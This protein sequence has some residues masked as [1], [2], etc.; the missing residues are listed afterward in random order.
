MILDAL[1]V[2][3][4]NFSQIDDVVSLIVSSA[5]G[6]NQAFGGMM[7]VAMMNG[8]IR[9]MVVAMAAPRT[10]SAGAPK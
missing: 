2:V 5:F 7:G 4:F 6:W 9:E 1:F 3:V 10:P 8:I